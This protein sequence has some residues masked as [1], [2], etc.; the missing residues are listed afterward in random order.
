MLNVHICFFVH[1][2]SALSLS[3]SQ[4]YL[5]NVISVSSPYRKPSKK[6]LLLITLTTC[7]VL[8]AIA[9]AVVI[10]LYCFKSKHHFHGVPK[11]SANA[12]LYQ[13]GAVATD[14]V[15]CSEIGKC[16]VMLRCSLSKF[17]VT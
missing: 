1:V 15:R 3:L 7:T 8:A 17:D 6:Q 9:V 12:E 4:I 10:T 2:I 14:S 5:E 13:N 16:F 11:S